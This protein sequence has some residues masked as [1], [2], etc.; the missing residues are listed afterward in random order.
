MALIALV[1]VIISVL[2]DLVESMFKRVSGIKDSSNII[3]GH[4]GL[5][6]RFDCQLLMGTFVNVYIHSFIRYV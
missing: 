4:G 1:T 2:G 3:P 5:M 6:D